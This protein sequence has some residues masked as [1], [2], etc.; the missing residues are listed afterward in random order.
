MTE[1]AIFEKLRGMIAEQFDLDLKDIT[2]ESSFADD[3]GADSIDL[4][5][6][7]MNVEDEFEIESIT[8]EDVGEFTTVGKCVRYLAAR[9]NG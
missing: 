2:M 9:L 8:E 5:E 4:V 1:E 7:M 3:F 6:L